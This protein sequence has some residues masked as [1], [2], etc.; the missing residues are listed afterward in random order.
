MVDYAL[1][2]IQGCLDAL[3][4][5]LETIKFDDQADRL[6]FVGDLVNR[7]PKSLETLR[8]IKNLP[9]T[10][11]ISLGNHDLHLLCQIFLP[12]QQPK[13]DDTLTEIL[14]APDRDELGHWLRAQPLLHH[15][16]DLNFVMTHAGIAP[17]WNIE[18][19]KNY[20]QELELALAG[21][22]Y[23][24]FLA[25]MYGNTPNHLSDNITPTE[26]LRVICNYFTRM[27]FC[28]ANGHLELTYKGEPNHPPAHMYPWYAVPTR[29]SL[30]NVDIIFGH[31]AALQGRCPIKNI[32]AI[33]TGCVW[34]GALTAL[35]LQDKQ[36]FSI[37]L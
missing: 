30:N 34:G 2:D 5:L 1:G 32:H 6:W 7:G 24:D 28:D 20:A 26:R 29:C 19:A 3:Q 31:W 10:P 37:S 27:R 22:D 36:H 12:N 11:R 18:E 14:N 21:E 25:H 9:I 4:R 17:C 23:L 15:D 13:P 16:P 8:F 33:D 35:R